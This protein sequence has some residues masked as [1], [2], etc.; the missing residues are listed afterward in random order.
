MQGQ[1]PVEKGAFGWPVVGPE[2]AQ[3]FAGRQGADASPTLR[4]GY[5]PAARQSPS[6]PCQKEPRTTSRLTSMLQACRG[7]ANL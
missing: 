6:T 4:N 3:G 1:E 5:K 2:H 7:F